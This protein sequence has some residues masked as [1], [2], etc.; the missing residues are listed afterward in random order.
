MTVKKAIELLSQMPPESIL[1]VPSIDHG[2]DVPVQGFEPYQDC[3]GIE[4]CEDDE[5]MRWYGH[6]KIQ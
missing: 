4:F 6:A 3:I 2:R 1:M 5:V